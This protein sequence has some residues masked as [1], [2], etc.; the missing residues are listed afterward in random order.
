MTQAQKD[1]TADQQYSKF[2]W[3]HADQTQMYQDIIDDLVK[4]QNNPYRAEIIMAKDAD[5]FAKMVIG[6]NF[7]GKYIVQ[8]VNDMISFVWEQHWWEESE[9][10]IREKIGLAMLKRYKKDALFHNHNQPWA[11]K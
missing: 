6:T 9:D 10:E 4:D 3:D 7:L 5:D 11:T 1:L 8:L 2:A